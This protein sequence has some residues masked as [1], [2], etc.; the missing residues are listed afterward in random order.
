MFF[1]YGD[2]A[3][4]DGKV[5]GTSLVTEGYLQLVTRMAIGENL[6]QTWIDTVQLA[7]MGSSRSASLFF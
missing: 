6:G 3:D 5:D 7:D 1:P 4:A 2:I